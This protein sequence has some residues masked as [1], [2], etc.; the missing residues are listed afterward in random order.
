ML[1][2]RSGELYLPGDGGTWRR[3]HA[4]GIAE[5]VR[6]VVRGAD[7][8]IW[9][10]GR[11]APLFVYRKGVWHTERLSARGRV[12]VGGPG[13]A[14]ALAV[15][16]WVF[17]FDGSS[18]QRTMRTPPSVAVLWV[19]S[20]KR[21]YIVEDSGVVLRGDGKT[22]TPIEL[23]LAEGDRV[24][25]LAGVAGRSLYA[26]TEQGAIFSIGATAAKAVAV[27]AE[28]AGFAPSA[29]CSDGKRRVAVVGRAG[30]GFVMAVLEGDAIRRDA[31][32]ADLADGD[33]YSVCRLGPDGSVLVSS[34]RGVVRMRSADGI[35]SDG[36][37]SVELPASADRPRRPPA[38]SR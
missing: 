13:S 2:G 19:S 24:A 21:A 9:A 34:S 30:G 8:V 37:V 35:W 33:Y 25:E 3:A 22:W 27:P 4:G 31:G 29:A 7:G 14:P 1:V 20:A 36:S 18:W 5:D 11:R 10:V 6:L 23:A 15:Q 28:L 16:R 12:R 32:L 38:R 26:F 17:V